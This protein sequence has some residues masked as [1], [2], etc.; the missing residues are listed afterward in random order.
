MN[1]NEIPKNVDLCEAYLQ[2]ADL[3]EADFR[4]PKN[5]DLREADLHGANLWG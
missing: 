2:G 1:S 4:I 5:M 3:R